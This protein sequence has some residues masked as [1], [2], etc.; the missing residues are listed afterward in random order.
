MMHADGELQEAD[1]RELMAFIAQHPQLQNELEEYSAVRLVPDTTMVYAHKQ[2]L[3]KEEPAAAPRIIAFPVWRKYSIA[4]AAAIVLF[5]SVYKMMNSGEE[6][7]NNTVVAGNIKQNEPVKKEEVVM[8]VN[9]APGETPADNKAVAQHNTTA[10]AQHE[11][12]TSM[13]R[14]PQTVKQEVIVAHQ[15]TKPVVPVNEAIPAPQM[16]EQVTQVA[17]LPVA[18]VKEIHAPQ[19]NVTAAVAE[20]RDVPAY[21]AV[22][23]Q[24]EETSSFLDKL[25]VDDVKKKQLGHIANAIKDATESQKWSLKVEKKKIVLSF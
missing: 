14:V 15:D 13:R 25:P 4:A 3:L 24:P 10:P 5:L 23:Q 17:Q 20:I 22:Q 7:S 18:S 2:A 9:N 12:V 8:P 1:E 6:V 11:T 21:A 16:R 19:T